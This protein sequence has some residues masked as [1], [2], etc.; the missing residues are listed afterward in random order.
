MSIPLASVGPMR[1]A[2]WVCVICLISLNII[3]PSVSFSGNK[4][5]AVY[6][7]ELIQQTLNTLSNS[8]HDV[9]KRVMETVDHHFSVCLLTFQRDKAGVKPVPRF[10][11]TPFC[12]YIDT[13]HTMIHSKVWHLPVKRGLTINATILYFNLPNTGQNCIACFLLIVTTDNVEKKYCGRRLPWMMYSLGKFTSTFLTCLS[14]MNCY[15]FRAT[16]SSNN[17]KTVLHYVC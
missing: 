2:I 17:S 14:Y 12:G 11:F 3:Q 9:V 13:R 1:L 4:N 6:I 15:K 7:I 16:I 8:F 5:Q 10:I